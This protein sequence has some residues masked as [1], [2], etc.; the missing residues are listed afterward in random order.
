[1]GIMGSHKTLKGTHRSP[2][3]FW[4]YSVPGGMGALPAIPALKKERQE[5]QEFK[6]IPSYI[7]KC[8]GAK[9]L[10][11]WGSPPGPGPATVS[12]CGC[13]HRL[14]HSPPQAGPCVPL[15]CTLL[16]W[17]PVTA[18]ADAMGRLKAGPLGTKS[19]GG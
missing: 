7:T 1:M 18:G 6:V 10:P 15:P 3:L 5:D 11:G 12:G 4:M 16:H 9:V 17:L 19:K 13:T 14:E 2:R 8:G